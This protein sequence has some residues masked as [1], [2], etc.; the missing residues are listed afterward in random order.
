MDLD[1]FKPA[2]IDEL[3]GFIAE[4][5]KNES[6]EWWENNTK[7]IGGYLRSLAE[8]FYQTKKS[9]ISQ[10]ITPD[11]AGHIMHMQ[12]LAFNSILQFTKFMTFALLQSLADLTFKII[13]WAMYNYTGVNLFPKLVKPQ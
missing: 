11:Q 5:L 8:A 13:G 2:D 6:Q 9:L 3:V 10:Q 1:S 4:S 12:E 7:V